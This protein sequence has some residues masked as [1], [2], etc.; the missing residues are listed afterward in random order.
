MEI[1]LLVVLG[2]ITVHYIADFL[3]QTDEMA[4]NKSKSNKHLLQHT[5]IYSFIWLFAGM[6]YV[7]PTYWSDI[8]RYDYLE[9]LMSFTVVFP[10]ITFFCHTITDYI[11]SRIS[12]YFYKK[13]ERHNFFLVIGLDQ[14]LHYF[15]LF[16]TFYILTK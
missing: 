1:N 9:L 8:S 10:L 3:F 12:S 4:I 11:T 13:E 5:G 15:Q 2:I 16:L 14:V 7:I 6:C